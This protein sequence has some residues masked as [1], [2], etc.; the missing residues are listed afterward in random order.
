VCRSST[1]R[2]REEP[3]N[4]L[5]ELARGELNHLRTQT[6]EWETIGL[7]VADPDRA[8]MAAMTRQF[9]QALYAGTAAESDQL[10]QDVLART[11]RLGERIARTFADQL[12]HTRLG[13]VEKLPTRLGCRLSRVPP[14]EHRDIIQA[15]FSAVRLVPAW[16]EIES[17]ESHYDWA[18]FDALVDW[19]E[20]AGLAVS[21]G[22][23]IDLGGVVPDWFRQWSGDLPSVAAFA[24]DFVE[25]TIRRYQGRVGTWQVFA[26]FN[27]HEMLGLSEDDRIR[28][29][30]RLLDSARQ[31]DPSGN[32]VAGIAQPWGDYLASDD[33]TY[34]PLVFADTLMRA[35][36]NLAAIELEMLIAPG[37]RGSQPRDPLEVF[38]VLE[39]FGVL[40]VS[41]EA[42]LGT[43]LRPPSPSPEGWVES[44]LGLA[45]SL[46]QV[47]AVFWEA[48]VDD[49]T[50][51][52]PGVALVDAG[53]PAP[54]VDVLRGLRERALE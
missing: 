21:A 16:G 26:G 1:L 32:W 48:W 43:P 51:R 22:P 17:T 31:A 50:A 52:V 28:L 6:A 10:S 36:F 3:Y 53:G 44:A 27:H 7:E 11:Y 38:R 23:L 30:A 34:S 2:E 39:L 24:C 45:L 29:A 8:E 33:H 35:G 9:G 54:V 49:S 15:T 20:G 47:S 14:P 46:P 13:E 41:L 19:A 42:T 18:E 37:V 12:F 25:T 4:L 40:G 5:I